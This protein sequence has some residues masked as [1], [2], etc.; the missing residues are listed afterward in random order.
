MSEMAPWLKASTKTMA[1]LRR[2]I[3]DAPR[4]QSRLLFLLADWGDQ[5][6]F[7]D[8][9]ARL[10]AEGDRR[11]V[12]PYV[13]ARSTR[14]EVPSALNRILGAGDTDLVT[15]FVEGLLESK[16]ADRLELLTTVLA[17]HPVP[18]QVVDA[19]HK[20]LNAMRQQGVAG[21]DAVEAALPPQPAV[22]D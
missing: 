17:K 19:A 10:G 14:P 6:V 13:V 1:E 22:K 8:A 15:W 3:G 4:D 9:L 18:P 11:W 21:T 5:R 16:R 7:E 2:R 20:A 12:D